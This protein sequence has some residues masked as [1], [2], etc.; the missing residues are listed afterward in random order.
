[1]KKR[2]MK[3][4]E[5]LVGMKRRGSQLEDTLA[6]TQYLEVLHLNHLRRQN[7]FVLPKWWSAR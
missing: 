4:G 3:M 1:M 5:A 6:I 7:I 2:K